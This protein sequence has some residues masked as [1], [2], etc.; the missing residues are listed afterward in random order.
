MAKSEKRWQLLLV[1]DD[2]R[3]I[4][5]KRIKGIAVGVVVLVVLLGLFCAGLAWQ[6]TAEKVRHRRTQEAL[7]DADRKVTHYKHEHEL[8]AAELVLAEARMEKAGLPVPRRKERIPQQAAASQENTQAIDDAAAEDASATPAREL[9]QETAAPASPAESASASPEGSAVGATAD[10][11]PSSETKPSEIP[12]VVA[13][14]DLEM[15]HDIDKKVLMARFRV[16]NEGPPSSPIAGQC[17]VVLKNED[18]DRDAWQT[19]PDV[20]MADGIPEGER[21][22]SFKISRFIDME[23]IAPVKKDPSVFTTATVYVFDK[24]GVE[25][26]SKDFPIT[27]PAPAPA[28]EPTADT[29]AAPTAESASPN[30]VQKPVVDVAGLEMTHDANNNK[31]LRAR[32]RISNNGDPTVPVAGRCVVV[33]HDAQMDADA[34]LAMPGV[35]LVNGEPDGSRGQAFK[36]SRFRDMEI[37]SM[38]QTDRSAFT[39]ASIYVFDTSGTRLLQKDFPIQLP[40]PEPAPE[41]STDVVSETPDT[42]SP[43]ADT[44]DAPASAGASSPTEN[45]ETED[46]VRSLPLPDQPAV[47]L[48]QTTPDNDQLPVDGTQPAKTPDSRARF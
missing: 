20:P 17:V 27:L 11:N 38:D 7:A 2:G 21:G 48:P 3:I 28:P 16:N 23:I 43:S 15:E 32:F 44:T 37:K 10:E 22:R 45:T 18:L 47:G 13:L 25:L 9:T 26:L 42:S 14:G 8:I 41:P 31:V 39:V 29:T 33:L 1:A 30:T 40:A 46:A 6:L 12:S 24:S 4:P 36:I 5:F 35:D 19:M 34:W